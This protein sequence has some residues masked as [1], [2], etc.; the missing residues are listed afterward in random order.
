MAWLA[1]GWIERLEDASSGHKHPPL[2]RLLVNFWWSSCHLC[3][4]SSWRMHRAVT[5]PPPAPLAPRSS[6]HRWCAAPTCSPWLL[7]PPVPDEVGSAAGVKCKVMCYK[8]YTCCIRHYVLL[9]C[10]VSLDL[11]LVRWKRGQVMTP[12]QFKINFIFDFLFSL[13]N[14]I[15]RKKEH[16]RRSRHVFQ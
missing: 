4:W 8:L 14:Q 10:F 16:K 5:K 6:L 13:S 3:W 1:L 7:T 11:Y 2:R 15:V 9:H 12:S